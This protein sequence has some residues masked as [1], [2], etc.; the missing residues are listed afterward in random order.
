LVGGDVGKRL[1]VGGILREESW[2]GTSRT[3]TM[4]R[5]MKLRRKVSK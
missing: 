5:D 4:R 2:R 3:T 1:V